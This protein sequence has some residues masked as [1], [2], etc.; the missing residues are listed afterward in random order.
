MPVHD[1]TRVDAGIFHAFHLSWL[2]R[3]QDS[4]N[5]GV[6]PEGYYAL[7]EQHAGRLIPDIL[8]LH[9]GS[10]NGP[11]RA[12]ANPEPGGTAVADAP[13]KMRRKHSVAATAK[14]RRRSL[15]I[16][17]VS[18]HR[19]VALLEV[20]SPANKDRAV[21]V[22]DFVTNVATALEYGVHVLLVD[23]FPP[24]RYDPRGFHGEILRRLEE[25]GEPYALPPEEP[26]TL[27]SYAA[28]PV[29]DMYIEHIA[30]GSSLPEMPLFFL[31]ER[32]VDVPLETTYQAA[33][34]GMP[35]F[36]RE[37]LEKPQ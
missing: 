16:R 30:I 32:Y 1:W 27:A 20:I 36:W 22:E 3:L 25:V 18:G 13:P 35:A 6:L 5:D 23:L 24:G 37:I 29:I 34:H 12:G 11:D 31:P 21:S 17:H 9:A 2:G 14:G 33:Y 15:A 19:L 10:G 26:L 7:A 4:L 8:T 28:A